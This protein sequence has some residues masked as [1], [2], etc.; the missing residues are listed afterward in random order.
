[1]GSENERLRERLAGKDGAGFDRAY[2]D[3]MVE[4]HEKAVRLFT[5]YQ[6]SGGNAALVAFAR[7]TL[8]V[9]RHH[10]DEAKGLQKSLATQ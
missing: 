8:P 7:E 9:L 5:D 10:L 2:I 6:A 4:D 3:A 1:M